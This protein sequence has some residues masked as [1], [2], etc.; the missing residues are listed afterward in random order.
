[1]KRRQSARHI[2]ETLD[3]DEAEAD[4][5]HLVAEQEAAYCRSKRPKIRRAVRQFIE[6]M[7]DVDSD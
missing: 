2:V 6:T 1:M 7:A 4:N 5:A 3:I